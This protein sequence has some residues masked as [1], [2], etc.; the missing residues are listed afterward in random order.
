MLLS[1]NLFFIWFIYEYSVDIGGDNHTQNKIS[2]NA[3]LIEETDVSKNY[4]RKKYT[5]AEKKNYVY[6]YNEIKKNFLK[7]F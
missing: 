1:I 6:K 4:K 5:W 7:R 3:L 2:E